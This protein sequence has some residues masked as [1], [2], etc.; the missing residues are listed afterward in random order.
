VT[1]RLLRNPLKKKMI[2]V[3]RAGEKIERNLAVAISIILGFNFGQRH[4]TSTF[5]SITSVNDD[6]NNLEDGN[7]RTIT[8]AGQ[9]IQKKYY[10]FEDALSKKLVKRELIWLIFLYISSLLMLLSLSIYLQSTLYL[11]NKEFI[12][13]IEMITYF[14]KHFMVYQNFYNFLLLEILFVDKVL[15]ID[16]FSRYN[17]TKESA[18]YPNTTNYADFGYDLKNLSTFTHARINEGYLLMDKTMEDYDNILKSIQ[19]SKEIIFNYTVTLRRP[20][21]QGTSDI[22]NMTIYNG[23]MLYG[24]TTL[25]ETTKCPAIIMSKSTTSLKLRYFLENALD[26]VPLAVEG[27]SD[28]ILDFVNLTYSSFIKMVLI[29]LLSMGIIT[30]LLTLISLKCLWN[31]R[32]NFATVYG[33]YEHLN[34]SE[35]DERTSQLSKVSYLMYRFKSSTFSESYLGVRLIERNPS[36]NVSREKRKNIKFT[37]SLYM[38]ELVSSMI[39]ILIFYIIQISLLGFLVLVFQIKVNGAAWIV[40]KQRSFNKVS[41]GQMI[42]Y[43]M[44][45]QLMAL[46]EGSRALEMPILPAFKQ[47]Q[48]TLRS[49][50]NTFQSIF[51]DSSSNRYEYL[52]QELEDHKEQN[53]CQHL[54][55]YYE[56]CDLLDSSIPSKGMVQGFYRVYNYLDEVFSIV[57]TGSYK[58]SNFVADPKFIEWVYTFNMLYLQSFEVNNL[59]FK[60]AATKFVNE[61]VIQSISQVMIIIILFMVLSFSFIYF[62]FWNMLKQ[63]RKVAFSFQLISIS[64]VIQNTQIKYTFKTLLRLKKKLL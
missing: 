56:M 58:V 22:V 37:Q 24:S 40:Q 59:F 38:Y 60:D 3:A 7:A 30:I 19:W 55:K 34:Q 64:S 4:K 29:S 16:V 43:N 42:G 26:E 9:N 35:L 44:I 12:G 47:H 28:T 23:Y 14:N 41:R 46:G 21:V 5:K 13:G 11:T 15:P 57:N 62:S 54:G 31:I 45:L 53:I 27:Y 10:A 17:F 63:D 50:A 48:L 36:M 6:D 33:S 52:N 49:L 51:E 32:R 8:S 1:I 20:E 39:F 61:E 25:Y 2:T 18:S